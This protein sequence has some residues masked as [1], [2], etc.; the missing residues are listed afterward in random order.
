MDLVATFTELLPIEHPFE[1]VRVEK[2]DAKQAVHFYLQISSSHLPSPQHTIH[3]YYQRSWEHL[4][5]F[6]YRSFIH[7]ALPIYRDKHT[8]KFTKASI[9]FAR[10]H[11]RFTLLYEQEVMR[12]MGIHHCMSSVARQLGIYVQ[13]VEKIYHHY[14]THLEALP[15]THVAQRVGVDET[16]T[17]KGHHYITTFVDMDSGAILDIA[18]GKGT[19]CIKHFFDNH[20]NPQA[21]K[22]FSADMSPAFSSGIARY[23]PRA[24][25]TFDQWHVIK[26]LYKHLDTLG[27]KAH[28][29]RVHIALLMEDVSAFCKANQASKARAQLCFIAH[30]AQQQLGNNPI[31]ATIEKHFEGIAAY[32]D[33]HLTNG[34]L[35]GINSKIQ[36][37]KRI[38]RGF[39]Y[40]ENFKKM[41]R[42]AFES[43]QLSSKII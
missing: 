27:G 6:Q 42:F 30:F 26:L 13:R 19:D 11:A 28:A 35:E 22:D 5:L 18:D 8:G 1:L 10:D 16:S 7:C 43:R 29:F 2:E 36:I 21:V 3:S 39:R 14:T 41:I 15:I 23:F 37:I 24:R 32:F 12:L 33:S 17:R 25:I 4:K 9:A 31:S 20:P 34:L 40:Q 38:A